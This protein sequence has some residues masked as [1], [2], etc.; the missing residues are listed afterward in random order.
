MLQT[1]ENPPANAKDPA[2]IERLRVLMAQRGLDAF[3]VPRYDE[4]QGEYV[5]ACADRLKWLTGFTGSAGTAVI[6]AKKAALF[7][8]GRYT[9]Q[10]AAQ[11]D[12]RMLT[13]QE[14]PDASLDAWLAH[15]IAAGAVVG[16]DPWLHTVASVEGLEARLAS[17]DV[18]LKPV[19]RNLVDVVWG[20]ERP[21]PPM[22][23]VTVHP[24]SCAG[25]PAGDKI[26]SIQQRL[27]TDG[28]DAVVLTLP[29]SICWLFNLRG[30]DIPRNPVVLAFAIVTRQGK[31][32]LFVDPAKFGP[33]TKAH[34]K[35][36][37]KLFKPEALTEQLTALKANGGRVRLD[38]A[39]AAWWLHRKLGGKSKVVAGVD[40]CIGLKARK[41][42]VEIAG[43]RAAH[44]RDG[45]AMV[46][47]LAWLDGRKPGSINEIQAVKQL[48]QERV[49]TGAL[50]DLSFETISGAGPNGAI[51][52]YRVTEATNR[53]L[54]AGELFLIDSG[55][56]YQDGTTDITRTVAI[57]RPSAEMQQRYTLVLKGH[58]AISTAR[59][60]K[61][62]R[63]I[64]LDP[65]A[66]MALWQHG[67]DY[68][69]GTGHGVGSYL[70]VHE[71]PQSIS[72]RGLAVIEPG[73]IISN[74]PGYYKA[75]AYGIRIENLV[76]VEP[77]SPLP[78]GDAD[79]MSF[80]TLTL[81]P[82]DRRLILPAL[83][84][85]AER[86]WVDAYHARVLKALGPLV[87]ASDRDWLTAATAPFG[88][89]L[90]ERGST[91]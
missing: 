75:G 87:S 2:R 69:H 40:P 43:A 10:A 36:L 50:R 59:F 83:L 86:A 70:S 46:R 72:K 12:T 56:Q 35:P 48:E 52:H 82:Y 42:S 1:F 30:T 34:L 33:E 17:H 24:L 47:Y 16:F 63:G 88:E 29:D 19:P 14:V 6:G 49:A 20:S 5:A 41:N 13:V 84:S 85:P 25:E 71:G 58:I 15:N 77:A 53:T 73:M 61:G 81:A 64:D 51:V 65:L 9:L 89:P 7:V 66:R 91:G 80:E 3:L 45:A 21:A 78:G 31:P 54:A 79:M 4:H 27:K 32:Q 8:D 23:P 55:G 38:P 68:S 74:E 67:L 18:K 39:T 28:Q 57:G 90:G 22:A 62:T 37:A 26:A 60:P 44:V 76:L 11:V